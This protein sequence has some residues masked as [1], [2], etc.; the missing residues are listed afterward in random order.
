MRQALKIIRGEHVALAALLHAL[1]QLARQ[2]APTVADFQLLRAV[3]FYLH[4]FPEKRHHRRE[5]LLL[6]PRIRVRA[7]SGEADYVLDRL[8]EEHL[9]GERMARELEHALLAWEQLGESRRAG[10]A[11]ACE[12]YADFYTAHLLLE[13]AEALPLAAR[14]LDD[15]DWFELDAAFAENRD[16]LA[17]E[18]PEDE[19]RQLFERIQQLMPDS[20]GMVPTYGGASNHAPNDVERDSSS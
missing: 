5:S 14:L 3:V 8:D 15:E 1:R 19:Y 9:R 2:R 16:A 13:E 20:I 12:R 6:F 18:S 4:E 11:E 17:G 7:R 10:F